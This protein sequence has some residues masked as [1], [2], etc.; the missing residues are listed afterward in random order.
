M[1]KETLKSVRENIQEKS[2]IG[3]D[4]FLK[5]IDCPKS[6][7]YRIE[8]GETRLTVELLNRIV[9]AFG[10]QYIDILRRCCGGME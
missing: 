9:G 6:T 3:R 10:D 2:G 1:D 8:K 4:E 7:W 5:L